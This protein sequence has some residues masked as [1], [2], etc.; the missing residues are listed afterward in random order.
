RL[1]EQLGH[2]GVD[3][4]DPLARVDHEQHQVGLVERP[5]RLL[6]HGP[7]DAG[8]R[9]IE[10]ARVDDSEA[11]RP[12]VGLAVAAI[13]GHPRHVLDQRGAAAHQAVVERGLPH[14]GASDQRD[15][16]QSESGAGVAHAR[17]PSAAIAWAELVQSGSIRTVSL[18][19]AG[20]CRRSLMAK[21]ARVPTSRIIAPPLPSTMARWLSRSTTMLASMTTSAARSFQAS[22]TTATAYGTSWRR[23][24]NSCSRISS[25]ARKRSVRSVSW[26]AA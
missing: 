23:L 5:Q 11:G 26:S 25:A 24:T 4:G 10:A 6:A 9:G 19:C 14:V 21:R 16:R 8:R 17:Y 22:T 20:R 13:A 3:G 15:Q 7:E 18:R 12:P 1:A 2:V